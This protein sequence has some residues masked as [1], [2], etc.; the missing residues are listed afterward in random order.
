MWPPR[1]STLDVL[2]SRLVWG[3]VQ[4]V[5]RARYPLAELGCLLRLSCR[6]RTVLA[7]KSIGRRRV[8]A[9][10]LQSLGFMIPSGEPTCNA[11]LSETG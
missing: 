9:G 6:S 11:P 10:R 5:A 4:L 3:F 1:L 8:L 7:A 2:E